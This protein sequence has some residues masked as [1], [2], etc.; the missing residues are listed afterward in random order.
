MRNAGPLS[1][2]LPVLSSSVPGGRWLG[3]CRPA[4]AFIPPAPQQCPL[5]PLAAG[6]SRTL[7]LASDVPDAASAAVTASAE[8][9]DL[10][11]A[12]NAA[13]VT[14]G[15]GSR[16]RRQRRAKQQA[17][18]KG[19]KVQVAAACAPGRAR[20]TAAFKVRGRTVG[21]PVR[22]SSRRTRRAR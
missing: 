12:D 19:I 4:S 11:P 18:R 1:A 14:L 20:V 15:R 13:A 2:D 21:S 8:G 22:S 9:P 5:A 16:V 3:E 7:V 17:L 6:E 10:E